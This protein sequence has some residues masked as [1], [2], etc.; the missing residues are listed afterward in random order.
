MSLS[1]VKIY[2]DGENRLLEDA[3][4]LLSDENIDNGIY[5]DQTVIDLRDLVKYLMGRSVVME[6]LYKYTLNPPQ[7][8]AQID[9]IM[10]LK[11][12]FNNEC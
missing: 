3:L 4:Q 12:W 5:C 6:K 10:R 1:E 9:E 11:Q 2:V 7:N 8:I